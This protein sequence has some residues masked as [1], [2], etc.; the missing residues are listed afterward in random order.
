MLPCIANYS[1]FPLPHS[2]GIKMSFTETRARASSQNFLRQIGLACS[3]QTVKALDI[4]MSSPA[5]IF[6]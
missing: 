2:S 1:Y 5:E 3:I 4:D 6:I